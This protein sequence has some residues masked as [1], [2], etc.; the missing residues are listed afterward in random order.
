M[1]TVSDD[2]EKDDIAPSSM[3]EVAAL[4]AYLDRLL[5][6]D[7]REEADVPVDPI[8]RAV[9]AQLRMADDGVDDPD[10]AFIERLYQEVAA[11]NVRQERTTV[12]R[13]RFLRGA[14]LAAAAAGLAGVGYEID[15]EQRHLRQPHSLVT[16]AGRWYD[17]AAADEVSH[18][19]M[20]AFTAGGVSGYLLND[21]GDLRAISAICTHMGC[22]LKPLK[23]A[24]ELRCL[25][26]GSRFDAAGRVLSGIAPD[27][28]PQIALRLEGGRVYA[29]GTEEDMST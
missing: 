29:Q 27:P 25:C 19:Q 1:K 4:D 10:P 23:G 7:P 14:G 12:S 8:I 2:L 3:P 24:L 9:A 17:I 11:R 5:G 16:G 22:R 18:G 20:K 21:S 6:S 15:E 13:S 28:L 26:H